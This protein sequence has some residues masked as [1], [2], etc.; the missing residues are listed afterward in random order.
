MTSHHLSQQS[1]EEKAL[2]KSSIR[3]CKK[4]WTE[5][6][7]K[8]MEGKT[9]LPSFWNFDALFTAQDHP[10]RE[11]QDNIF[12]KQ[13]NPDQRQKTNQQ[14]QAKPRKRSTRKFRMAIQMG[15]GGSQKTRA[16]NTHNPA[17]CPNTIKPKRIRT[18]SKVLRTRKMLPKRNNRLES[19]I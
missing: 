17:V 9:I 15:G 4:I 18:P 10:V 1:T 13:K 16:K 11:M 6:G 14:N 19:R 8:E 2:R 3:L 7:F 12:H 5:L